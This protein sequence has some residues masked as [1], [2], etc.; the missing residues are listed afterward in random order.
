MPMGTQSPGPDAGNLLGDIVDLL[1]GFDATDLFSLTSAGRWITNP[2]SLRDRIANE[3]LFRLWRA[4]REPDWPEPAI[5]LFSPLTA[6]PDLLDFAEGITAPG[7]VPEA[8]SR[9]LLGIMEVL[10]SLVEHRVHIACA[11]AYVADWD[12]AGKA[13][14]RAYEEAAGRVFVRFRASRCTVFGRLRE[15]AASLDSAPGTIFTDTVET[16]AREEEVRRLAG[17]G[18][19]REVGAGSEGGLDT[20]P[21]EISQWDIAFSVS[22]SGSLVRPCIELLLREDLAVSSGIQFQASDILGRLKDSRAVGGMLRAL[23]SFDHRHT[24]IRA[25]LVY[26]LGNLRQ[27]R[28]FDSFAGVLDG[29]DSVCV[30]VPGGPGYRQPLGAEKSEA[31]WALGKL[32][33]DAAEGIPGLVALTGSADPE[34]RLHLAWTLGVIG[35]EQRRITGG[36]DSDIVISLMRLLKQGDS[37]LFEEAASALKCL[38]LPDFIHT[39]HLHDFSTLPVLALKP[40]STGLYELSE[41]ILHMVLVKRPVVMAVTGDSGT[42]KTYFCEAITGGFCDIGASEIVYLKRDSIGDR[43]LDRMVGLKWLRSNVQPR[44]W[45]PY[46]VPEDRDDPEAY[47]VEFMRA[48]AS[49]KLIILDG[50]RDQAYFNKVIEVFYDKGYLDLLVNFRTTFSTRRLNL[51]DREGSLERVKLHLPL[52]EEPGIEDTSFYREGSVLVYN[53]DNSIPSRLDRAGIREVFNRRK[54]ETWGDQIRIGSFTAERRPLITEVCSLVPSGHRVEGEEEV[55][56]RGAEQTIKLYESTFRRHLNQDLGRRPCLLETITTEDFTVNRIVF[57]T[58][59]RVAFCGCD[60]SMG[61]LVGFNDRALY[62]RPHTSAAIAL[63]A[64]GSDLYSVGEDG[65]LMVLS[66]ERNTMAELINP[67]SPVVSLAGHRGGRLVTGHG[68]GSVRI[69]DAEARRVASMPLHEASVLSV[70]VGRRGEVYSGGADGTV[71]IMSEDL[72]SIR[73]VDIPGASIAVVAPYVDGRLAIATAPPDSGDGRGGRGAAE[74]LLIDAGTGNCTRLRAEGAGKVSAMSVYFDGRLVAALESG[75]GLQGGVAVVDPGPDG[76]AY[77]VLGGHE[78]QTRDC[79]TMGPRIISCGSERGG[80][81]TLRIWGAAS[82]VA[83]EH[84]KAGFLPPDMPK[85]PYYRSLF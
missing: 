71:C 55:F 19:V 24:G 34:I 82:Y 37:T 49:K 77:S 80:S 1:D 6:E 75:P 62:A 58:Q 31:I 69:W 13:R 30:E 27:T 17:L 56:E 38:D 26:A 5:G 35:L 74:V 42:G 46:P 79:L 70:A 59:G 25:N 15:I 11:K 28:C 60:G 61:L 14:R 53:L 65:K 12:F 85:P 10:F 8:C 9:R 44:F 41:T 76:P 47:F 72:L 40:S 7:V 29:P 52:V 81:H 83:S 64:G 45:D 48:N 43:T 63:A 68:D 36:I 16:L 18:R 84:A 50:W 23:D 66:F 57:H 33:A 21:G 2:A 39:L 22:A 32:G 3:L 67:G 54:I 20:S 4:K 73:K 78:A 51:E